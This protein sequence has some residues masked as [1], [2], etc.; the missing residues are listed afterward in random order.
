M[1]RRPAHRASKIKECDHV[2]RGYFGFG[3]HEAVVHVASNADFLVY[4][5]ARNVETFPGGVQVT[6]PPSQFRGSGS[7]GPMD[8]LVID[9]PAQTGLD[10]GCIGA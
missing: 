7:T 3:D 6:T 10:L 1:S 2:V 4:I 9:V 5:W 8:G